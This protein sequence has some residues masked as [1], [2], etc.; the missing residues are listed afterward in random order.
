MWSLRFLGLVTVARSCKCEKLIGS[1]V[2]LARRRS[3]ERSFDDQQAGTFAC[4]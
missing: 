3:S 4:Q 1:P 2:T